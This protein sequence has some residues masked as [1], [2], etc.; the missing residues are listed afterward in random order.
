[1]HERLII[2]RPAELGERLAHAIRV[3]SDEPLTITADHLLHLDARL[4]A[5]DF[6]TV[7]ALLR[8]A[9]PAPALP[10]FLARYMKWSGDL[11]SAAAL[12][13][14]I[15]PALDIVLADAADP[16]L[17]HR[18]CLELAA[19]ATDLGDA[20]LAA[21]LHGIARRVGPPAPVERVRDPHAASV[22]DIAFDTL[23]IEP[24]AAR[25]RL[26]LRPRLDRYDQLAA[27]H[28]RFGDASIDITA[29]RDPGELV[30]RVEQ[31][32]GAIPIT[33][34]LEP[35]IA[36]PGPC[37]VDGHPADL[38]PQVLADGTILPVQ[39]VLDEPRTLVV[40]PD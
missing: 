10:L 19:T 14:S 6:E 17:R 40:R 18:T 4:A 20:P 15:L 38:S 8:D 36:H 31:T 35:Y 24:D 11:Q 27:H 16:A 37:T 1:M 5:G 12:W 34:L 23:G 28:I 33:V 30:V 2:V 32:A 3:L 39:L 25:G 21:R 22:C 7:L 29:T 13:N 9:H 26:R